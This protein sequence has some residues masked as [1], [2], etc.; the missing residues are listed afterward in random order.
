MFAAVSQS[1][2][3]QPVLARLISL[4][5]ALA[6]LTAGFLRPPVL[7]AQLALQ[8][9][10]DCQFVDESWADGDSFPVRFPDGK[11]R[12]IRLY[13]VDCLESEAAGSDSNAQRLRDQRRW[14]GLPDMEKALELGRAS[15]AET[16][17]RLA[18]PFTVHTSFADARGDSRFSRVY[19][20]VTLHDGSDLAES[21]VS[22]GLARAFG[23]SRARPDGTRADE[24]KEQLNDLELRAAKRDA[25]AWA[26]TD[27]D[28]LADER[29]AARQEDAEIASVRSPS[30][31]ATDAPINPNLASRDELLTLPGVGEVLALR[32]IE[33]RPF[34]K[35]EDLLRVNG[36]GSKTLEKLLPH[37]IF[38]STDRSAK[39][40]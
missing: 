23:V 36:I 27:W 13:G 7:A 31:S 4:S 30:R 40:R 25:G 18:K 2:T 11:T 15:K 8:T 37:M 17:R 24:W 19:A 10:E 33:A 34:D 16:R 1:F 5:I 9:F 29:R 14:F 22:A 32:I 12:T 21:L 38:G 3:S 20:F 28:R 26:L 35:P 39:A 6:M